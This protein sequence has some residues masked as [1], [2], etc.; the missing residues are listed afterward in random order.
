MRRVLIAITAFLLIATRAQEALGQCNISTLDIN[1]TPMLCADSGDAWEWAGPG[2]FTSTDMCV[3]ASAPG[4]YTLRVYDSASGQ[5]SAPCS[6]TVG[7]PPPGPSCSIAGVD[8]VCAGSNVPWCGPAGNYD[9][10]WSGPGGFTASAV[11]VDV[12][13]AGTYSLTLT[14]RA[15]GAAGD[16]CTLTLRLVDCAP[17]RNLDVCPR[18]ARWWSFNC[19]SSSAP[20]DAES[21]ASVA[22][23]VDQRSALW[24]YGGQSNGLCTLLARTRHNSEMAKAQRQFAAVLANLAAAAQGALDQD[25]HPIGLQPGM[26]LDD[27]H[28]VDDGTT[29]AS[30]VASAEQTL[31]T[32]SAGSD[33]SRKAK[34]TLRRVRHQARDINKGS[35]SDACR[36]ELSAALD[37]DDDELGSAS[38]ANAT[39]EGGAEG[40]HPLS[41]GSRMSWTLERSGHVEL[42]IMDVTG[43]RMRHLVSGMFSAGTHVFTWDGRDDDG[44]AVRAGVYFVAGTIDGQRTSQRLFVLH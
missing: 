36:R 37:D 28:G 1:G 18:T 30:W 9:Y 41:G 38:A 43:R 24:S 20:L 7:S 26:M 21:F 12:S 19:A 34:E 8:S 14:D 25:G 29:L 2:G 15:S 32:L 23:S 6:Q 5:W 13:A 22:A 16:A 40:S 3:T 17:Q 11:C 4:T 31:L 33:H 42:S 44:R 39:L 10:A 27:V 35:R